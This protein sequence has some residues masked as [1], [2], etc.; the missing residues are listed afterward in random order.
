MKTIKNKL[1]YFQ[2]KFITIA[3]PA[4]NEAL[5]LPV[6]VKD[7]DEVLKKITNYYEI[8]VV[9]DGSTD[10]SKQVL[11][12]LKKTNKHLRVINF[13]KNQGVGAALFTIYRSVKGDILFVNAADGQVTMD[14][15]CVML[16]YLK[17]ND[18]VIGQRVKRADNLI[19]RISSILYSVFLQLVFGVQ[20]KDIDSMMMIKVSALKNLK[21]NSKTAFIQAE[22]IIK[23]T[24]KKLKI[25]EVPIV[26]YPR[27]QGKAKGFTLK[28]V[29]PQL[30]DL[31]RALLKKI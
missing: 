26:H 2:D 15:L 11:E 18:I 7:A 17:K 1:A 10:N 29:I 23:A 16:P 3:M 30:I 14:Q 12:K 13:S 8:L 22:I 25:M 24:E 27:K 20:I 19:R 4:Y 31:F 21:I 9:N 28:I 6:V 5:S